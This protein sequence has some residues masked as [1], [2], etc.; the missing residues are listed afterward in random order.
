VQLD[1]ICAGMGRTGTLSLRLA[2]ETLGFG[3]CY[4]M[5]VLR[6]NPSHTDL[7]RRVMQGDADWPAILSGYRAVADE[8]AALYWRELAELCP[9]AKVVLN[10]RA[11]EDW[12]ASFLETIHVAV[13][14]RHRVEDSPSANLLSLVND[15]IFEG[16]FAGNFL[17]RDKALDFFNSRNQS[18]IDG[19]DKDRL[20]VYSVT[21][22][23]DPLCDFLAVPVPDQ[24]F[25]HINTR[26]EFLE[27]NSLKTDQR[28]PS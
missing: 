27:R 14:N 21:E 24:P 11:A 26:A 8:P 3:P 6:E 22:G 17:D 4:H 18:V 12:Y 1:V 25:P 15:L 23:W 19:V 7:W 20:L 10:T 13:Q 2:L 9:D 5:R 28:G 16:L